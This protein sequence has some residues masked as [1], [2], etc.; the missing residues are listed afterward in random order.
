MMGIRWI[1]LLVVTATS[2]SLQAKSY[3]FPA[4][5]GKA[6]PVITING[7]QELSV[8]QQRYIEGVINETYATLDRN[9]HSSELALLNQSYQGQLTPWLFNALKRCESWFAKTEGNIS[10]RN[11]A[12]YRYWGDYVEGKHALSRRE[13]RRLARV[14]R[15]AEVE[16]SQ[17][18]TLAFSAPIQWDLSEYAS[19]LVVERVD[20]YLRSLKMESF[21][22]SADDIQTHFSVSN[23]IWNADVAGERMTIQ[24]NAVVHLRPWQQ[25]AF[26]SVKGVSVEKGVISHS[27]GW[28]SSQFQTLVIAPHAFDSEL[29]A[30]YAATKTAQQSIAVVNALPD[31]ELKLSDENGRV[32]TSERFSYEVSSGS[33]EESA[34]PLLH[35]TVSLPHFNIADYRGPYVSVWISDNKNRLIKSLALR[36]NSERWLQE[37]RTWW[38]RIGRKNQALIDGFAGA[39]QKNTPL[40]LS[41]DG[42]DDFGREVTSVDLVFNVEV[43]REH[44]GRSVEKI[45]F[46][47]QSL[48]N[49]LVI[50]GSGEIGEISL[51]TSS[52]SL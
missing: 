22:I 50:K 4:A 14:A 41:W 15:I 31:I 43:A 10:C 27:D 7:Q 2:F 37:L 9:N 35:A 17:S 11:G 29:L 8:E 51:T 44:G 1:V 16:F 12:L 25:P 30:H 46:S 24:N 20:A 45:P 18:N 19:S 39:T 38:R 48:A 40:H 33:H 3:V 23:A 28:A 34:Q 42:K 21:H 36:G 52:D 47:L 13:V 6:N 5:K 49:P 26:S 32:Y